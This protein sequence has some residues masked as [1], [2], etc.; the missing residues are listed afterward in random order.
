MDFAIVAAIALA[1]AGYMAGSVR[2]IKEGNVA[3]V[4]RLGKY[5]RTMG[6]GLNFVVPLLDTVLVETT[7]EQFIDIEPQK[8]MTRDRANVEVDAILFWRILDLRK[9]YYEVEELD[10]SLKQL[11]I[12]T[13]RSEIGQLPL[14]DLISSRD[15]INRQI[16]LNLDRETQGWGVK[17][18]RVE[19]QEIKLSEDLMK[20]RDA[21]LAAESRR[22]AKESEAKAAVESIRIISDALRDSSNPRVTLQYLLVK[23]YIEAQQDVSKSENAKIIFMDP[24]ALTEA[25]S[26]FIVAEELEP[27][28]GG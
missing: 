8:A 1:V 23:S 14:E 16:M 5:Q 17:I 11:V 4:E 7:R 20:A 25:T 19:I 18:V 10:E 24:K 22:K 6:S 9:A 12:T 3:V 21:E 28:K 15:A 2:I 26:E 27:G 13:L